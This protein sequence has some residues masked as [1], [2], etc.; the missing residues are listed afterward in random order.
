MLMEGGF[1]SLIAIAL[2]IE[3]IIT[4]GQTI[5]KKKKIQ[6][7]IVVALVISFIFCYNTNLNFFSM[8]SLEEKY[9]IIGIIATAVALSRGSNYMFEFYHSLSNWR[10]HNVEGEDF[11]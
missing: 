11:E 5:Y 3:A 9:P 7:Q 4:Y 6:W 8:L 2:F 10:E 1:F